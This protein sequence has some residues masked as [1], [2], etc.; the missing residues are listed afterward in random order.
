MQKNIF[1]NA[2]IG[3]RKET[4]IRN[5]SENVQTM[6]GFERKEEVMNTTS[7]AVANGKQ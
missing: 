3:K 1:T 7:K 2:Q 5:E 6:E 4:V